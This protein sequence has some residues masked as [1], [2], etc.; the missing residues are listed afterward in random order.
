[1]RLDRRKDRIKEA[2]MANRYWTA[3]WSMGYQGTDSEE[4]LD[5][6]EFLGLTEEEV[7]AMSDDDA[8]EQVASYAWDDA[9]Q[10]IDSYAE[11]TE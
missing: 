10:M 9:T 4:D 11:P 7:E 8:M 6:V 1:M 3:K 5:L 2:T